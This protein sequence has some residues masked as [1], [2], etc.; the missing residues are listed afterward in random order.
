MQKWE[1]MTMNRSGGRW[2]DDHFDGRSPADKLT[3]LGAEGWEL[4]SVFYDGSAYHYYLKRP[5]PKKVTRKT[6]AK[7]TKSK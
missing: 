1:Y 5:L 6:S 2:S 4:V 3:E 7:K